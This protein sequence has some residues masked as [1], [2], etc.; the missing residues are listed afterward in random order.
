M[1]R[2]SWRFLSIVFRVRIFAL[3]WAALSAWFSAVPAIGAV[4]V[5]EY[6]LRLWRAGAASRAIV[7]KPLHLVPPSRRQLG[8]TNAAPA[9][10]RE[11]DG[12]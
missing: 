11:L 12:L 2:V 6:A 4:M 7:M 10:K 8:M 9:C 3:V 5:A 1:F